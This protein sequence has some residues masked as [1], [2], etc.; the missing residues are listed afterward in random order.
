MRVST[1]LAPIDP[2]N[3]P[4]WWLLFTPSNWNTAQADADG[5]DEV[6]VLRNQIYAVDQ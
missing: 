3:D 2:I 4:Q 5:R 6:V 1:T